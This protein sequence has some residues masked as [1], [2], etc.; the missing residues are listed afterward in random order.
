[1]SLSYHI[2]GWVSV[3]FFALSLAG[4]GSQLRLI[5]RRKHSHQVAVNQAGESQAGPPADSSRPTAVLSLNQFFA[6][7]LAFYSFLVYGICSEPFNHYLVWTRLPAT[8]LV[9]F[10]LYEVW[11]DRRNR[12]PALAVMTGITLMLAAAGLL[13]AGPR[14]T[15]EGRWVWA[16]LAVFAAAVFAQGLMHQIMRVRQTGHTGAISLHMHQL[17]TCKDASTIAFALTMQPGMGWP[18]MVVGVTGVAT[19]SVLMWHFRWVDH[20]PLAAARR[21]ASGD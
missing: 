6:S 12:L 21:T 1:M 10:I 19:K 4:I 14:I 13:I 17:T 15:T 8:V 11:H 9:L 16:L 2:T 18:L 7:F 3:L 20:S 5:W